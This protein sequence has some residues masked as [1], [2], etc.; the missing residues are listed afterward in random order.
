MSGLS[1]STSPKAADESFPF[2]TSWT[3]LSPACKVAVRGDDP[4]FCTTRKSYGLRSRHRR[5]GHLPNQ[6]YWRLS[7]NSHPRRGLIDRVPLPP[8]TS[9]REVSTETCR[10]Q[11]AAIA[12]GTRASK[13][14]KRRFAKKRR[15]ESETHFPDCFRSV[16]HKMSSKPV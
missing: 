3:R 8:V 5:P 10:L 12:T 7:T 4:L 6:R 13:G 14:S 9:N 2:W 11:L 16:L 15:I 1:P